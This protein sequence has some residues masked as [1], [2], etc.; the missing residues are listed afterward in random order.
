MMWECG[1]ALTIRMTV[2]HAT[3]KVRASTRGNKT[4][5]QLQ[6]TTHA[7][8]NNPL[9]TTAKKVYSGKQEFSNTFIAILSS[10]AYII[11]LSSAHMHIQ[12]VC[13]CTH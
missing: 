11:V 6:K 3:N 8:P 9:Y 13:T 7:H 10:L 1:A 5:E 2:A 4:S 12:Y